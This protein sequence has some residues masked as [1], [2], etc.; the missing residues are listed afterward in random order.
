MIL[1]YLLSGLTAGSLYA[2]SAL[3]F[4]LIYKATKIVNFAQGELVMIGAYFALFYT[5]LQL[6]FYLVFLF[7]ITSAFMVGMIIDKVICEPL[8]RAKHFTVIIATFALSYLMRSLIRMIWGNQYYTLPSPFPPTTYKYGE[9]VIGSQ[10][11]WITVISVGIMSIFY[12]FFRFTKT[13]KSMFATAQNQEAASLM[14][15]N[16]RRVFMLIW[17]LSGALAAASGILLAPIS[18]VSPYMGLI[19]IKAFVVAVLGGFNSLPG[20]VIGGFLLGIIENIS[21]IYISSGYKD[22][23]VFVIFIAVLAIKPTGLLGTEEFKRV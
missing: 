5:L 23:V 13:G 6:P 20:A 17:G 12:L 14:G 2:N 22:V 15:V 16:I 11:L 19:G 3:G 18:A 10:N 9:L 21:I 1:Q 8:L 4:V 7:S